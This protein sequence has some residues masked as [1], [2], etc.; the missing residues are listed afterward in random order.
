MPAKTVDGVALGSNFGSFQAYANLIE[1]HIHQGNALSYKDSDL[2]S[3][4]ST[5]IRTIDAN[6]NANANANAAA[7]LYLQQTWARP[8]L[9]KRARAPPPSTRPPATP[10]TAALRPPRFT[11][12]WR[13]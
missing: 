9:I 6:A 12:T 4:G 2:F 10:A 1:N 11:P 5:T 13:P 8:N 7:Q 3:G